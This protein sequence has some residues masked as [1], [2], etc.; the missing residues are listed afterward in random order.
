MIAMKRWWNSYELRLLLLFLVLLSAY[1]AFARLYHAP[2]GYYGTA[3]QPR[4]ADPWIARAETIVG[5]GLL[6][7]DVFTATPPLINFLLIPPALF[8]GLFDHLNPWATLS[9]MLYFSLFNLFG[10]YVLLYLA[11][12][13][14]QGFE[15]AV[16]FLL[17][18]LTFGNTVLR[19]QD[20]SILAFF[21]GLSLLLMLRRH[22][23]RAAIAIGATVLIKLT[24]VLLIPVA[25]AHSWSWKYLVI[26]PLV[27]ALVLGPFLILAGSDAM[28][29]NPSRERT[30]HP[31]KFGGV[32]LGALWNQFHAEEQSISIEI[33]SAMFM[34]GVALVSGFVLWKRFG[35]L[36]DMAIVLIVVLMLTPKLHGGYFS[37]LALVMAPLLTRYRLWVPYFLSGALVI[38]ADFY[39][40]PLEDFRPAFW[41]MVV[42][43]LLLV[44]VLLR[45]C[46]LGRRGF[47]KNYA[48]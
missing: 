31:F 23:L 2:R 29:W 14:A 5:G 24:G 15:A 3:E 17:N 43:M 34:A 10:A 33:L 28:F 4:F 48:P 35:V 44:A 41:M 8:S 11:E 20:E 32:S 7:R 22:H 25:F 21:F 16:Y 46:G 45:L 47:D 38:V 27:F 30:Q 6:Y 42:V 19:R 13:K 18:P 37:M 40:W 9:F 1:L 12:T 36:E 26:P 39:K